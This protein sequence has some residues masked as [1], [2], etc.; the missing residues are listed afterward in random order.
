MKRRL[1]D[2]LV[3]Y[4]F[5]AG[6]LVCFAVFS[7]YPLVR[8]I[9]LSFQQWYPGGEPAQWVGLD[10]FRRVFNDPLFVTAWKN[11]FL[12]TAFALLFGAAMPLGIA[13]VM[14]ELRHLKGFFRLAVYLPVM[15]PPAVTAL[16]WKFFYDPGQGLFNAILSGL[17]LP[18]SQWVQSGSVA[19]LSLVFLATWANMGGATIIY[20][21][22][23]GSIPGELYEAAEIDGA[24]LWQR[25]RNV[26]LPQLRFVV[27]V[28]I[29][30]QIVATMQV[31]LE[32]YLLTGYSNNSTVTVM[33]LIYRY[34]FTV[35]YDFGM[36]AAMSVLLFL[37][38]GAFSALYL[39]VTRTR[40]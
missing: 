36:A 25:V 30:L 2:N 21:A 13:I 40:D 7:W 6:A 17:H 26:M 22:A 16:L 15:L 33:I 19:M 29:L 3:A 8:G 37:V 1:A 20:L 23:L 11:T 27:L 32:P 12:F 5:M 14:N 31:F 39:W 38:L 9:M 4:A 10:N 34:A 18:T 35:N 24:G 28:L